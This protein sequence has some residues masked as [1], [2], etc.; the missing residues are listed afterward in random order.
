MKN[1]QNYAKIYKRRKNM[2]YFLILL[3]LISCI[4]YAET[5]TKVVIIDSGISKTQSAQKYM[6]KNGNIN[7]TDSKNKYDEH[8]HGTNILSIISKSINPKTHC[9]ISVKVWHPTIDGYRTIEATTSAIR[10]A[11][12][13]NANFVNISMNGD[14]F[15]KKEFD[16]IKKF[17]KKGGILTVAAG[18]EKSNLNK[19][20]NAFPACYRKL[21][22]H[23]NF[24]VVGAVDTAYSNFGNIVTD[25]EKGN[26]VG[27]PVMSG[28]SQASA[29]KMAK[30]LKVVVLSSRGK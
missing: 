8:G 21:L 20:C 10:L 15:S 25:I 2:K 22:P 1:T 19:H 28:T 29:V 13:L 6:C 5:R 16:A 7:F 12:R 11:N 3:S 30:I 4:T 26:K 17:V 24:H 9:V 23:K 14:S 27:F 18:N